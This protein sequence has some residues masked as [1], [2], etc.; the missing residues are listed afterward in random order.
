MEEE[1]GEF[2]SRPCI[3]GDRAFSVGHLKKKT[4]RL[5]R[6]PWVYFRPTSCARFS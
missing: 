6:G 4:L 2:G 5:F 3:G 1:E